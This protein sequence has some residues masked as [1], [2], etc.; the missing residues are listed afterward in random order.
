MNV[1][2]GECYTQDENDPF[3]RLQG[4]E[5]REEESDLVLEDPTERNRYRAGRDGDHLM[6]PFECDLCHFRNMNQRDP[7]LT[8]AKDR[9]TMVGIRRSNLDALWARESSTVK[10]NLNRMR[11]DY[12]STLQIF[13]VG[14]NF[15]PQLGNPRLEDR[16]GMK[17]A[18]ATLAASLRKGNHTSNVQFETVRRTRTW[19]G[20][21]FDAGVEYDGRPVGVE[22]GKEEFAS[23]SP[24]KKEWFK[25]FMKGVELRMGVLRIQNEALTSQQ[26]L[27]LLEL[28]EEERAHA[29]DATQERLE[30]LACYILIGFGVGLRGE[31]VPLVSTEGLVHFWEETGA[32]STPYT[33]VTLYGRFKAE[34]GYRWHCLPLCEGGRSGIPFRAWIGAL[35]HRRSKQ[36]RL[37][38]Y[39]FGKANG[40]K[41]KISDYDAEFVRFI[42]KLHDSRPD[43][44]SKGTSLELYSL[45]R[46]LR[47]G[48]I[49]ETTG[50]VDDSVVNLVNRWR[51]KEGARGAQPGLSMRQTYTQVR[52]TFHQLKLYSL[53][54]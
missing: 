16:V 23:N 7:D 14:E 18:L 36:G 42:N 2:C 11:A 31:E 17:V 39:L 40:S 51:T 41:A 48:A 49:L 20:D 47:R 6:C 52:D 26:V 24:T 43:L 28:I 29:D 32:E 8:S 25:R 46:S 5:D 35:L 1:W 50:R 45:R 38:G 12:K 33:M 4:L 54:L 53:A 10:S 34:T 3:P 30:E 13:S 44:F 27:G 37:T 21:V 19:Y 9:F 15:L 22:G